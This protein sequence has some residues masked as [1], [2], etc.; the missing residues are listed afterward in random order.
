MLY[1]VIAPIVAAADATIP[2]VLYGFEIR[3]MDESFIE[4]SEP[5]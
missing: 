1:A 2:K 3:L 5:L 4:T